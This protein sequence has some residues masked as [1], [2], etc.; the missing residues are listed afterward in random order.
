MPAWQCWAPQVRAPGAAKPQESWRKG[1]EQRDGW[2]WQSWTKSGLADS[3]GRQQCLEEPWKAAHLGWESAQTP[4]KVEVKAKEGVR[5]AASNSDGCP[6]WCSLAAYWGI[7]ACCGT[8]FSLEE[9]CAVLTPLSWW[10]LTRLQPE[11]LCLRTV[12][13]LSFWK[14][15]EGMLKWKEKALFFFMLNW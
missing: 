4:I 1:G 12:S 15:R 2:W 6:V 5:V 11:E 13:Y 10:K 7:T 14:P 8:G 9:V 3:A